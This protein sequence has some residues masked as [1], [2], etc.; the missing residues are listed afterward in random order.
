VDGRIQRLN[1]DGSPDASFNGGE[2]EPTLGSIYSIRQI[3]VLRSGK[4]LVAGSTIFSAGTKNVVTQAAQSRDP[5]DA[6]ARPLRLALAE[7]WLRGR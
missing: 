2:S 5:T 3:E 7:L 4:I 1:P 6:A